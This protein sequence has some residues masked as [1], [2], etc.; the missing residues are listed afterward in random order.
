[1]KFNAAINGVDLDKNEKKESLMFPH[2]DTFKNMSKDEKVEKTKQQL[3]K[4]KTMLP[5]QMRL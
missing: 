2:P 4:H 3:A 5:K 1:M